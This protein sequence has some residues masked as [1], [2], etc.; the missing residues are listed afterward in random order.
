MKIG[1]MMA[2]LTTAG[3]AAQT[4]GGLE[5][6]RPVITVY[7]RREFGDM[8]LNL[9]RAEGIASKMFS[10]T[11]VQIQWRTGWARAYQDPH[12]I[13]VDITTDTPDTLQPSALAYATAYEGVH[14]RIFW[15]RIAL[16]GDE[17]LT[18]LAHVLAHEITHL[19][20]GVSRHSQ[21]GVM[22]AHWTTDDLLK[23]KRKPLAFDSE[24]IK[25]IHYGLA[26]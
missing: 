11:G 3:A 18:L 17:S 9:L 12:P 13:L 15:D 1:A 14:I 7:V 26:H 16:R 19:L 4:R 10:E 23:M 5:N 20:Q 24:D 22:K 6:P 2:L 21:E 25:L 8:R